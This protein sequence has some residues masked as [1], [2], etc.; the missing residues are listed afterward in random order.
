MVNCAWNESFPLGRCAY[1]RFE[2]SDHQPLV[3]YFNKSGKL[4]KG[5][6]RFNRALTEKKEVEGVV[7]EAW[8][9]FPLHSV[10]AKLNSCRRNI[11]QWAKEQNAKSNELILQNQTALEVELYADPPRQNEIEKLT[12]LPF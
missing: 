2:G 9:H 4:K 8:N 10:I 11:I 5:M 1:L 7:A 3:T 6:F 12:I